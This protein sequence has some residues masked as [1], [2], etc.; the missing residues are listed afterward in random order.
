MIKDYM[1]GLAKGME[2]RE[3]LKA[4]IGSLERE[5][6]YLKRKISWMEFRNHLDG[7]EPQ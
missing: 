4:I 6:K 3:A 5:I 1:D 2:E 7:K